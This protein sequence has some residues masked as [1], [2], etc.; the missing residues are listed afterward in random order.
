MVTTVHYRPPVSPRRITLPNATH[1]LHTGYL[2]WNTA[3]AFTYLILNILFIGVSVAV[4]WRYLPKLTKEWWLTAC[5]LLLLTLVFDN[6][7]IFTQIIAYNHHLLLGLFAFSAPLEDF[8]YT[9]L[10]LIIVP[11]LW[12]VSKRYDKKSE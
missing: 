10:A 12:K 11:A 7:L 1:L 9:I 8:L 4:L 5:I 6:V 2:Q 3:M